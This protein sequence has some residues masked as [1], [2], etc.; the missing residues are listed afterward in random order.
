MVNYKKK[1]CFWFNSCYN[2]EFQFGDVNGGYNLDSITFYV[3]S[4][5]LFNCA[6]MKVISY[7]K[8]VS[9]PSQIII[10]LI[11][12]FM[13]FDEIT[14]SDKEANK[15]IYLNNTGVEGMISETIPII[16]KPQQIDKFV[17]KF[18]I[19]VARY[20]PSVSINYITGNSTFTTLT[21]AYIKYGSTSAYYRLPVGLQ[22]FTYNAGV[23]T[24]S[25]PNFS[26]TIR[27]YPILK[28]LATGL[29]TYPV[30]HYM[31]D[32]QNN[33]G[34]DFMN[35]YTLTTGGTF[36]YSTSV[37]IKG[38][39]AILSSGSGN[40]YLDSASWYNIGTGSVTFAL[41]S[42][43]TTISNST[44]VF[45]KVGGPS[46]T[47]GQYF[48]LSY[49]VA[50]NLVFTN[51]SGTITT[52]SSF[53]NQD[54]WCHIA[55][56]YDSSSLIATIYYNGVSQG[57]G[58]MGIAFAGLA[59]I[60]AYSDGLNYYRGYW[61]DFRVYDRVLTSTEINE[62]V[63]GTIAIYTTPRFLLGVEVEDIDLEV[64]NGVNQYK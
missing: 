37:F 4:F 2:D 32:E 31:F 64:D 38:S 61:D 21:N 62:L 55:V 56:T 41:W 6:K 29:I 19:V 57:N 18:E 28:D 7:I 42:R 50:N 34:K 58:S 24:V 43:R 15:M 46:N 17:F 25:N 63:Y 35:K 26:L 27:D 13:K 5:E 3:P 33:L 51:G 45:F 12:P 10:K 39:G 11:S 1:R 60:R 9:T 8:D 47:A 59:K 48:I 14:N 22:T 30:A 54:Q 20:S 52:A 16:L 40:N 23:I 36:N 44:S 53:S 49:N